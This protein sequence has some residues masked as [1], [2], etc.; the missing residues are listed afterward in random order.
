MSGLT[1]GRLAA[2][3]GVNVQTIRYYERRGLLPEPERRPSGYRA[4]T[5]SDVARIR[6]IRRAQELGFT[7]EEIRELL[8]LRTGARENP[9]DVRERVQGKV[10]SIDERIR[11]LREIRGA[12]ARMA[13]ACATHGPSGDCPFLEVLEGRSA[14]STSVA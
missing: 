14:Q 7:L 5:E 10:A 13:D 4:Y 8:S 6:F 9:E 12:L 2:R 3:A 11:D 1:T